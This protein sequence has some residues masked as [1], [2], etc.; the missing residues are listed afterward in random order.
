MS[1]QDKSFG[2]K[3]EFDELTDA[4][5]RRKTPLHSTAVHA[6][7]MLIRNE[8]ATFITKKLGAGGS[9]LSKGIPL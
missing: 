3:T 7:S 8:E 2:N 4:P 6:I 5:T 1:Q 9:Y